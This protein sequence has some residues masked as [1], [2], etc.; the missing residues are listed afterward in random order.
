MLVWLFVA[1]KVDSNG[2][3]N[4]LGKSMLWLTEL[5]AS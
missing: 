4:K 3:K 2:E 5:Q 1:M